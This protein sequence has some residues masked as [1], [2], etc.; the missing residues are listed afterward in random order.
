MIFFS[1]PYWEYYLMGIIL[2]PGIILSIYAQAKMH[3]TFNKYVK[4]TSMSRITGAEFARKMLNE[5]E[6]SHIKIIHTKGTLTDY[7]NHSKKT[8]ALSDEVYESTSVVSLGIAAHEIGHALQYKEHYIPVKL[9]GI[10]VPVTNL[11]ST[12]L[13]PLVF[14]GLILGFGSTTGGS[15]GTIFVWSGVIFFGLSVL[16]SLITLPVELDASRRAKRLLIESGLVDEMESEGATKVL[17]AAALTYVAALIIAILNLIRFLLVVNN[18][19]D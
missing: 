2:I 7:Y 14:I 1:G 4:I 18:R 11:V 16:F 5:A 6:L 12:I 8:I 17:N 10:L 9:R 3:S 15:L 19:R 13:W